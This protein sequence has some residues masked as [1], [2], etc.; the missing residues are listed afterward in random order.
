MNEKSGYKY[1]IR[2]LHGDSNA[3]S[4]RDE[5]LSPGIPNFY[6]EYVNRIQNFPVQIRHASTSASDDAIYFTALL[7]EYPGSRIYSRKLD[8]AKGKDTVLYIPA[9]NDHV[10]T[11]TLGYKVTV[12]Q[13]YYQYSIVKKMLVDANSAIIIPEFL[14]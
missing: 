13:S 5:Y 8:L 1:F 4:R 2:T 10:M 3:N 12:A 14:Y 6:T 7:S 9:L 11:M